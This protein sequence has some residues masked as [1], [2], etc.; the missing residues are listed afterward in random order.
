[1]AF[2]SIEDST[3]ILDQVI[4]FSDV[5]QNSQHKL[6]NGATVLIAGQKSHK[7]GDSDALIIKSVKII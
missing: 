4:A 7:E 2:I 5:W 3:A 1:M 6:Y